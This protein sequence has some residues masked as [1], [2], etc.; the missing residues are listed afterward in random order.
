[1]S[2]QKSIPMTKNQGKNKRLSILVSTT[3]SVVLLVV[4][5]FGLDW[6][7]VIKH[8]RRVELS[9]IPVF[10]VL[11]FAANWVRAIRW[12][13]L[14]LG[15]KSLSTT[16]LFEAVMVGFL[17]TFLLP[18]RAG[19]FIR[20]WILSR[21]QPVS[22][23]TG[24][25]SVV[26]ERVFDMIA[27]LSL[28]GL[29]LTQMESVPPIVIVGTKILGAIG[30]IILVVM[31]IAYFRLAFIVALVRKSLELVLDENHEDKQEKLLKMVEDF[32]GGLKA[33]S[34]FK[35]LILVIFWSFMLWILIS[36]LYQMT[37]WAFGVGSSLWT[38]ITVCIIIGFA[39]AAPSSPGFIGTFQFGCVVALSGVY[40]YPREF[41][42]AYS[43]VAHAV[44][45]VFIVATGFI[46]LY[47][48]GMGFNQLERS[49]D[50]S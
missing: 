10:I 30:F 37:L 2:Y 38:G 15:E 24:L 20:P 48:E 27:L 17:A 47:I 12:N 40:T 49:A 42:I 13:L 4:I 26:I 1:M 3:V 6:E 16:K 11:L 36:V 19:E 9:Y 35:E 43:V 29:C 46:I 28:L 32:V 18:L 34:S 21:W 33:I 25:A 8:L 41:A 39:I 14:I 50:P 7:L 44:Q 31:I 22:F 5:V 45:F 23:S